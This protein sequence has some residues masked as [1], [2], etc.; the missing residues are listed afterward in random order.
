M[1]FFVLYLKLCACMEGGDLQLAKLTDSGYCEK[2]S[3]PL[4]L[5]NASLSLFLS[6][7]VSSGGSGHPLLVTTNK[8]TNSLNAQ[9]HTFAFDLLFLKLK[10]KLSNFPHLKVLPRPVGPFLM[11]M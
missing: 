4:P 8:L 9:A 1:V 10:R 6:M 11:F 3:Y 7:T 5:F 2:N